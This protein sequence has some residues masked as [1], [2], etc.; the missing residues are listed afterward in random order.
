[1]AYIVFLL[2]FSYVVLVR[3]NDTPSWQE[4]YVISYICTMG[5][6]KIREIIS[7]EPVAIR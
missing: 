5:C 4:L 2:V 3:M 7:S 6:E 1:M